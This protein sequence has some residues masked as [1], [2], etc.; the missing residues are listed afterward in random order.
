VGATTASDT[1]DASPIPVTGSPSDRPTGTN[2]PMVRFW[3]TATGK[4][5]AGAGGTSENF[6][7]IGHSLLALVMP[8]GGGHVSGWLLERERRQQGGEPGVS[9]APAPDVGAG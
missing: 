9:T 4:L 6:L 1:H 5:L 7:R 3:N 2:G 8:L